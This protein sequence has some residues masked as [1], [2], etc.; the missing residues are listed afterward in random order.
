MAQRPDSYGEAQLHQ[1]V[2]E[3]SAHIDNLI[4]DVRTIIQKLEQ[5]ALENQSI[6]RKAD[7]LEN[8][9]EP[10]PDAV[11]KHEERIND[12]EEQNRNLMAV[13][14]FVGLVVSGVGVGLWHL[15]INWSVVMAFARKMFGAGP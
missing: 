4:E 6:L 15:I 12:I 10:L 13:A 8:K 5:N 1:K 3:L 9:L 2:G 14:S 11:K 7:K